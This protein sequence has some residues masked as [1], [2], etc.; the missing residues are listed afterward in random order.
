M[1]QEIW[2]YSNEQRIPSDSSAGN[3]LREEILYQLEAHEWFQH[4]IFGVTLALEEALINAIKHGNQY[5]TN[6]RVHVVCKISRSRVRIEITDEGSGFNLQCIPDPT[7][8]ENLEKPSGRGIMLMRSYMSL[9]QY[10]DV[11]NCVVMEKLRNVEI[12]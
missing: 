3:L 7:E 8:D 2:T 1:E 12:S 10:N 4:D 9:V 5:D 6:K 11:G